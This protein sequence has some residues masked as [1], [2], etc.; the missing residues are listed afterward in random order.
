MLVA[1]TAKQR[2]QNND[3]I[4]CPSLHKHKLDHRLEQS[5]HWGRRVPRSAEAPCKLPPAPPRCPSPARLWCISNVT[6]FHLHLALTSRS[7]I[8]LLH[9][10]SNLRLIKKGKNIRNVQ[11]LN[12]IPILL[13]P[14]LLLIA[15][16]RK[17]PRSKRL[18]NGLKQSP[19]SSFCVKI[20]PVF[21]WQK[22]TY[23][24]P[25]PSFPTPVPALCTAQTL[26][27]LHYRTANHKEESKAD[28]F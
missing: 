27:L 19:S 9:P 1:Q 25:F 12:E 22:Q 11:S 7:F 4:L 21:G 5:Q 2:P 6:P 10:K 23:S 20:R 15:E 24:R 18:E 26:P 16:H 8:Q 14:N 13:L 17:H 3:K 28:F